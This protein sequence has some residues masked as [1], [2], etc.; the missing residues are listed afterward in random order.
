MIEQRS[1][2]LQEIEHEISDRQFPQ[3]WGLVQLPDDFSSQDPELVY[4]PAYRFLGVGKLAQLLQEG[5]EILGD[6][7]TP[8]RIFGK[9]HPASRPVFQVLAV[10]QPG[11]LL[12]GHGVAYRSWFCLPSHGCRME[13]TT[14]LNHC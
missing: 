3:R 9:P 5:P 6:L 7:L 14:I 12:Y 8:R 11:G 2:L 4:L 1:L 10:G 13:L